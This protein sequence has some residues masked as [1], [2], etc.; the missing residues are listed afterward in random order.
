MLKI[1]WDT[2]SD[3]FEHN[4]VIGNVESIWRLYFLLIHIEEKKVGGSY[5]KN[6]KVSNLSGVEI[7]MNKGICEAYSIAERTIR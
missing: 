4:F 5:P 3:N 2:V 6:I 7:P 1:E